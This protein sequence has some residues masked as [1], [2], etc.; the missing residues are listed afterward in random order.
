MTNM[1]TIIF[2]FY[3]VI[4]FLTG[5][6]FVSC[7]NNEYISSSEND[8]FIDNISVYLNTRSRSDIDNESNSSLPSED[9][10]EKSQS[11]FD[12]EFDE[13]SYVFISQ[14]TKTDFPFL[15]KDVIYRYQFSHI[16]EKA[17]W[18][19][20]YNF[21]AAETEHEALRWNTIGDNKVLDTGFALYAFYFPNQDTWPN[22]EF[23][24]KENQSTLEALKS[25]DILGAAHST[26]EL[27][28]RIKFRLFHLMVYLK[29]T[30]YVPIYDSTTKTGF[31]DNALTQASILNVIPNINIEWGLGDD[32]DASGPRVVL[33]Q[34]LNRVNIDMYFHPL[35]DNQQEHRIKEIKYK[36]FIP[37][38]Y[39]TQNIVGD[40]DKVRVY[41]LSV[42]VP[43]QDKNFMTSDFLK[44]IFKTPTGNTSTY[45]FNSL[46]HSAQI[47]QDNSLTFNTG[48]FEHLKLW[49]PR[50]GKQLLYVSANVKDWEDRYSDV[51][52]SESE[53]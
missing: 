45:Y 7:E 3:L 49:V 51:V 30:L 15:S 47:E 21:T 25:S 52:I 38:D 16:D 18:D 48:N 53:D 40:Y 37:S 46:Q 44:F 9:D 17:D 31:F 39:P 33:P 22:N 29:I 36:D 11:V 2:N 13:N 4:I 14:Q 26:E 23:R 10:D 27:Y 12:V 50:V 1:K 42:I 24:V 35:G 6:L 8:G 19:Y 5:L 41:N 43:I 34:E 32:P 28:S 20:G